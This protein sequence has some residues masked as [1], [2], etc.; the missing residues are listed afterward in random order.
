MPTA[1]T[2]VPPFVWAAILTGLVA[3]LLYFYASG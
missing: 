2:R 3:V 1:G